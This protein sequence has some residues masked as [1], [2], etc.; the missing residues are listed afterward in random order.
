MPDRQPLAVGRACKA[1]PGGPAGCRTVR[2]QP[3]C[4]RRWR[5]PAGRCAG[6]P[7][8]AS[9]SRTGRPAAKRSDVC[10]FAVTL[11]SQRSARR[12]CAGEVGIT[13]R[14][15]MI[16]LIHPHHLQRGAVVGHHVRGAAPLDQMVGP[17][18]VVD[19]VAGPGERAVVGQRAGHHVAGA[20]RHR[21]DPGRSDHPGRPAPAAPARRPWWRSRPGCRSPRDTSTRRRPRA[22]DRPAAAAAPGSRGGR[23]P[24]A[25]AWPAGAAA[26]PTPA[27]PPGPP[28]DPSRRRGT[29]DMPRGPTRRYRRPSPP[30]GSG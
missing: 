30:P 26:V 8:R 1:P 27:A 29:S 9:R 28:P 11:K 23:R 3:P 12:I 24:G 20:R 14:G 7:P 15:R 5:W 16:H 22:T 4:P 6:S 2:G 13:H 21:A 10:A 17:V 25:T 19:Q 18:H